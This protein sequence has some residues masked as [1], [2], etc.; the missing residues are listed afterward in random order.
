M[1]KISIREAALA[2]AKLGEFD[3][4]NDD[5]SVLEIRQA[6]GSSGFHYFYHPGE[7]RLITSFLLRE[8][9]RV[10]T[11]CAVTL[12]GKDHGFE[13]RFAFWKQ[14][15]TVAKKTVIEEQ[16]E[17]PAGETVTSAVKA[18]VDLGDCFD[19]LWKLIRFLESFSDV[20]LPAQPF[21]VASGDAVDLV[22]A[23]QGREKDEILL[24][25][26]EYLG[27]GVTEQDLLMLSSRKDALVEFES[28]LDDPD[29]FARRM[30]ERHKVRPED[31]WQAFF[32]ENTWIFGYGLALVACH[33][34]TDTKLEVITTGASV[35]TGAGKRADAAMRTRGFI[36]GLL[37]AEIKRPETDLLDATAYRPPDVYRPSGDLS[38]AVSQ[39]QK[40]TLKAISKIDT[41]HRQHSPSGEFQFEVSTVRPR[42]IVIAGHLRQLSADGA[43]NREQMSSFELFR[44]G[45]SDVE[46][47][48][49]DELLERA[50]FIAR[51][52]HA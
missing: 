49:F 8:G 21:K 7:R 51:S 27:Q 17:H 9:P 12:I 14:D 25:V 22:E 43:V 6:S 45:V 52:D 48:T 30:K 42:Q 29:Y 35:F 38:G 2:A 33:G 10:A 37:F 3:L 5:P 13:P 18:S 24:A 34:Y 16:V 11:L 23:L 32:E 47:I 41:L 50:R 26:K 31:T 15:R 46:V 44:K 28:M 19:T 20:V 4:E 1:V 39:V 36:Q 40:T